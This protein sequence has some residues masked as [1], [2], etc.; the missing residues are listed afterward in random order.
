MSR[1]NFE[2]KISIYS[3]PI[4]KLQSIVWPPEAEAA[5]AAVASQ[6]IDMTP[7]MKRIDIRKREIKISL[8]LTDDREFDND[9]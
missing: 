2:V 7:D 1:R 4:A 5:S 6:R 9:P 8:L 3:L